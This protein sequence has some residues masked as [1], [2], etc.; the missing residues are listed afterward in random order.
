[1]VPDFRFD[2]YLSYD[3]IEVYTEKLCAAYPER[4][5]KSS[6]GQSAEGRPLCLLTLTN[7]S[8]G[9]PEDR[10][11]FLVFGNMHCHEL[12]GPLAILYTVR[13]LLEQGG[14]ILDHTTF[15]AMPRV[16]PDGVE[17]IL[18]QGGF[19]RSRLEKSS[20]PNVLRQQ[21]IDG[22]GIVLLMRKQCEDGDHMIDPSDPL[23][24]IKRTADGK[25]PFFR[26]WYEGM[27]ENW[28]GETMQF[29]SEGMMRDWNRNW[30]V[31]WNSSMISCGDFPCSELENW[32]LA[33]FLSAHKNLFGIIN[34]HNGWGSILIPHGILPEDFRL[35]SELSDLGKQFTGYP[36][37]PENGLRFK[38][39][40]LVGLLGH[41]M[42]DD[43]AYQ[44]LGL[45]VLTVELGTYEHSAGYSTEAILDR[46]FED[47]YDPLPRIVG[48]QNA[49]PERRLVY[50]PWKPF[51]HP[52]L[53]P[54]EIGGCDIPRFAV[55]EK[56]EL[57]KVCEGIWQFTYRWAQKQPR[58]VV[59][60]QDNFEVSPGVN[61]VR[62]TLQN[63]GELSSSV[64]FRGRQLPGRPVPYAE[65]ELAPG[66]QCL[67]LKR[68]RE[69]GH[70]EPWQCVTLEW[71]LAGSVSRPAVLKVSA[72]SAGNL[73]Y[74]IIVEN[75]GETEL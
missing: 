35:Y 44:N 4:I 67:S 39:S 71:F 5:R 59:T 74:P 18:Q 12:A 13:K 34:Y 8:T 20:R 41:G 43:H 63:V 3:E 28:D 66:V 45:T 68:H 70:L 65:L 25:G 52:Q 69:I 24:L 7:F 47:Q 72:G 48:Y 54:V 21:D 30:P 17:K 62:V 56:E 10:P 50:H 49:H 61:R 36:A 73:E 58:I 51:L 11:A 1:M 15:Y 19:I 42:F 38:K 55:P 9:N 32:H 60:Q 14:E 22:N 40:Q 31:N 46:D 33:K 27:I 26:C 6:Y 75:H 64:T 37:P 23:R 29:E 57:L 2:P 53:G 16:N